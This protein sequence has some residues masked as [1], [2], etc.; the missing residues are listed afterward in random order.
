MRSAAVLNQYG[1]S[2]RRVLDIDADAGLAHAVVEHR[3]SLTH[4]KRNLEPLKL[5]RGYA[6]RDLPA[7]GIERDFGLSSLIVCA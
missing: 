7:C 6:H 4:G 5:T 2:D 3:Q 1:D